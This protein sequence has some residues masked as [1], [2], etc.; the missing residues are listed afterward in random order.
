MPFSRRLPCL[1]GSRRPVSRAVRVIASGVHLG[2]ALSWMEWDYF[3][4]SV[5]MQYRCESVR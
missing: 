3:P 2:V 5:P 4:G 1:L